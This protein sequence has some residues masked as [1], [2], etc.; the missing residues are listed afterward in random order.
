ML[1]I[2]SRNTGWPSSASGPLD[3]TPTNSRRTADERL[4]DTQRSLLQWY[5]YNTLILSINK[6]SIKN[7]SFFEF[8]NIT[9]FDSPAWLKPPRH[10]PVPSEHPQIRRH[11]DK[12]SACRDRQCI[13]SNQCSRLLP[14]HQTVFWAQKSPMM[15]HTMIQMRRLK[16]DVKSRLNE[17]QNI[18]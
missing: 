14:P 16:R 5:F 11:V 2:I 15:T 7:I 18:R 10:H 9:S 1:L 13:P 4:T 17:A 8:A 12:P 6:K 3:T